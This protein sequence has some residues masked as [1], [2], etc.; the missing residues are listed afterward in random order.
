[1]ALVDCDPGLSPPIPIRRRVFSSADWFDPEV[2]PNH[3]QQVLGGYGLVQ[4]VVGAGGQHRLAAFLK[5]AGAERKDNDVAALQPD[6]R[7]WAHK[8]S[9]RRSE[10]NDIPNLMT[11]QPLRSTG[12]SILTNGSFLTTPMNRSD[13]KGRP[14]ENIC[15]MMPWLLRFGNA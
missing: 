3:R 12:T 11:T 8:I 13:T 14:V 5:G 1:M 4:E 2:P 10:G 6:G 15:S 9:L 7:S